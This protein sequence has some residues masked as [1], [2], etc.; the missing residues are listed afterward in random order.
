[1]IANDNIRP[2]ARAKQVPPAV[3]AWSGKDRGD[4][5]FPVGSVLIARNLRE[6]VHAY[7]AFA[8]NAD[9]I[10]DSPA[11]SPAEKLARL[12]AMADVLAGGEDDGAPSARRLRLSFEA[13]NVP[14]IHARE[15]LIAFKRDATKT[16]YASWA[17]LADYCRYSA[18]PVGRFLLDLHGEGHETWPASDA[19][20]ASLQVLN[21]VQDCGKDL[22]DLDR[23]YVP[24]NWLAEAGLATD[25][26]ARGETVPAL[27]A[28]FDRMLIEVAALNAKAATLPKLIKTRRMRLEAAIIVNLAHKLAIKLRHGDP[29]ATRVKLTKF[30]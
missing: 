17:E 22:R 14:D 1:M 29:L 4:E 8:R 19:L 15:L 28:V 23:C 10:A 6:H 5:N 20:C 25:D 7:Y 30:F 13:S 18:A 11:L 24:Q 16:R 9:D 2:P 27:R 12:D 3:E 26:I 21:H